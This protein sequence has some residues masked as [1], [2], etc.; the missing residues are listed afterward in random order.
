M[1][2]RPDIFIFLSKSKDIQIPQM[3]HMPSCN[4][5]IV[6]KF[7]PDQIFVYYPH[8]P[9]RR[10]VCLSPLTSYLAGFGKDCETITNDWRRNNGYPSGTGGCRSTPWG[11]FVSEEGHK[12]LGRSVTAM[13]F[14]IGPRFV[15]FNFSRVLGLRADFCFSDTHWLRLF[16]LPWDVQC[17]ER[18]C[19]RKPN[20]LGCES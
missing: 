8:I 2:F 13:A 12:D 4:T 10:S 17:A 18:V 6:A 5:E 1:K 20:I 11:C 3:D 15:Q 19:S 9:A 16:P 14:S 7:R